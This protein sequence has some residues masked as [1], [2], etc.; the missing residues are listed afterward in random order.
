MSC[1]RLPEGDHT[2]GAKMASFFSVSLMQ[3]TDGQ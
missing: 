2:C 3:V 1:K